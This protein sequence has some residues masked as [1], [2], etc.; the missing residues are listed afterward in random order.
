MVDAADLLASVP[1][2]QIAS[3]VSTSDAIWPE[4][5]AP[6]PPLALGP[7]LTQQ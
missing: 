6:G 1:L 3:S 7:V 2:G 5:Y 4:G